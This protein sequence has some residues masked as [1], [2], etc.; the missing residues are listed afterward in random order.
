MPCLTFLEINTLESGK[1]TK[2][3]GHGIYSY[4]DG[5]WY[6]GEWKNGERHGIGLCVLPDG[7][8]YYGQW[9]NDKYHGLGL[10]VKA[11][12]NRYEGEWH[13]GN[14]HGHGKFYHLK[15]GQLQEGVWRDNICVRSNMTDIYFRQS[16]PEPT[17]Y[18][19]PEISVTDGHQ[20]QQF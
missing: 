10:Y 13:C 17:N 2:N 12:G 14:K 19:I 11:N 1:Q 3:M 20:E 16:A 8:F 18:P 15:S 7:S 4:S 5:S 6:Q 9:E